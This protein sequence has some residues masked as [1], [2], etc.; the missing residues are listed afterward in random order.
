MLS[1][2]FPA[3]IIAGFSYR[4][5]AKRNVQDILMIIIMTEIL[6]RNLCTNK[7][8]LAQSFEIMN[9]YE[10]ALLQ[11]DEL[12]ASFFQVLKGCIIH[13]PTKQQPCTL[14]ISNSCP[15]SQTERLPGLVSL[16]LVNR[17]TTALTY[18]T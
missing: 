7:E 3:G 13:P 15:L 8:G 6:N 5:Y 12:E 18:W 10:D 14:L 16:V 4:R 17:V 2:V 1:A 11:Y 9:L